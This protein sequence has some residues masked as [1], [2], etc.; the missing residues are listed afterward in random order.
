M[1]MGVGRTLSRRGKNLFALLIV[2]QAAHSVEEY[3]F[4][5]YDVLAPARFI[6]SLVSSNLGWGFAVVN[7][8]LVTFG[9]WGYLARVRVGH[10]SSDAWAWFW[11]LLEGA[12]GAGHL[13]FAVSRGGYFPGAWTAPFLLGLAVLLGTTLIGDRDG[14]GSPAP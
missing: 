2:A 13:L 12:N 9:A 14:G 10:P 3:A 6:S 1:L 5:L 7:A 4:H 11:V 8:A